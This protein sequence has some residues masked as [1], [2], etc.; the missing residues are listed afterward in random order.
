[1]RRIL[2]NCVL[3][4]IKADSQNTALRIFTTLNDRGRPLSDSDIFKAQF[5]KFY[6]NQ[7]SVAKDRFVERWKVLE[8]LCSK[9]FHPRKGTP[10]DDL[11]MRYMY[12]LLAK[13]GTKSDTFVDMRDYYEKDNYKLLRKDETLDDLEMLAKFWDDVAEQSE[14]FSPQALKKLFVLNYSPYSIWSY[15]V[16]LYFMGNRN[17]DDEKFSAFLDR[18]T[19]MLLMNAIADPG[20]HSIRRPFF[21]EFANILNGRPIEFRQFRQDEKFLR[22][23]LHNTKFTRSR[24]I[25]R[26]ML[27]WWTFHD[28]A[29]ELPPI[30]TKLEVEHIYAVKRHEL[31]PLENPDALEFLGNKALLEKRVNIRAA[32]YRFADKK[33]FY[34]GN[35]HDKIGTFNRELQRLAETRDDFTEADIIERNEE[36][37]D[38]FIAFLREQNL[39]V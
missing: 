39:L 2:N 25:T 32:D 34:L 29:Q 15:I 23:I 18:I 31:H 28:E 16:S 11:F 38:T 3:L 17:L 12:Y 33:I 27:V 36:I 14:R 1:M 4:P 10:V 7:S 22:N 21:V 35:G 5:Y 6:L 19:A 30:D 13:S 26:S 24:P 20:T 8:E 9:N 37:F